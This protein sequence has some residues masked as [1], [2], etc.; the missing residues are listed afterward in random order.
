MSKQHRKRIHWPILPALLCLALT[1]CIAVMNDNVAVDGGV[2]DAERMAREDNIPV[3]GETPGRT[4]TTERLSGYV[5]RLATTELGSAIARDANAASLRW[6]R[7][8]DVVTMDYRSDRIN[9][10]CD[11]AIVVT[12][13]SCG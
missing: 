6:I 5:G 4:C 11:N 7:P 3:R 8:D 10:R 13:F 2:S 1:G 9:V 12:G